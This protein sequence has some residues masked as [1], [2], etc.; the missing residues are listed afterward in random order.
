M[1]SQQ[2]L[3]LF[4]DNKPKNSSATKTRRIGTASNGTDHNGSVYNA[5]IFQL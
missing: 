2:K 3:L 1:F 4:I 5:E